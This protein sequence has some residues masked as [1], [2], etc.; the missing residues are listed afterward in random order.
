[1]IEFTHQGYLDL[2]QF[3]TDLNYKM[4]SFREIPSDG[5]YVIVRHDVDFSLEKALDMARLDHAAG[6]TSTFFFLVTTPYYNALSEHGV[7]IIQEIMGLGHECGLHY[8]C[9]GFERLS[10][11]ARLRRV[12]RLAHCLEDAAGAPIRV[13]AQHKPA[14]SPI[15]QEFP[16]YIDAY[17]APFFKD[18]GYVSDSRMLF[19]VPGVHAFFREHP[20]SQMVIHPI[21]WHAR[22]KTRSEIFAFIRRQ[23]LARIGGLLKTEAELIEAF[24]NQVAAR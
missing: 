4:V 16:S 13:I 18:I 19:R 22:E 12:D 10:S 1:M 11:D 21:W 6:V 3:I 9:T 23:L 14:S 15:R 24:L 20:R 8:D 2:L 17:S 7:R 5:P